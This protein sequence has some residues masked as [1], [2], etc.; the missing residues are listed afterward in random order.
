MPSVR[1]GPWHSYVGASWYP[2]DPEHRQGPVVCTVPWDPW[3]SDMKLAGMQVRGWILSHT[4]IV[5]NHIEILEC[6]WRSSGSCL[7]SEFYLCDQVKWYRMG[8][9]ADWRSRRLLAAVFSKWKLQLKQGEEGVNLGIREMSGCLCSVRPAIVT[10]PLCLWE[11]GEKRVML[12]WPEV[13][14]WPQ[15]SVVWVAVSS[16]IWDHITFKWLLQGW[17]H[18]ISANCLDPTWQIGRAHWNAIKALGVT[19]SGTIWFL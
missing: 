11:Q 10:A 17:C 3:F 14:P 1:E 13:P 8:W 2:V 12:R 9:N 6:F 15:A 18:V 4:P 7:R 5:L 16:V 19:V